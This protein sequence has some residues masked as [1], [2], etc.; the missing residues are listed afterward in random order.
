M[1][2]MAADTK[3]GKVSRSE[4]VAMVAETKFGSFQGSPKD[5]VL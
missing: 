4:M 5:R 2:A 1:V 3:F